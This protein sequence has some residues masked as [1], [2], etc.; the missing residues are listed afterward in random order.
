MRMTA[1]KARPQAA[2]S[3]ED[4]ASRPATVARD[5]PA[6][7]DRTA[8]ALTWPDGRRDE[9]LAVLLLLGMTLI[10]FAPL[11]RGQTL[12]AVALMQ[13]A[14]EPWHEAA[15]PIPRQYPQTDQ[16]DTFYPWIVF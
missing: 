5:A 10:F 16:A 1:G 7:V 11:L 12:S 4:T 14:V 13:A 3:G 2:I 6:A 9:W 15:Q 8:R